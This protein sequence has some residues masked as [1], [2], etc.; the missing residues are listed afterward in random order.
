MRLSLRYSYYYCYYR[1]RADETPLAIKP[2]PSIQVLSSGTCIMYL[3]TS[4]T[5]LEST[6]AFRILI[7]FHFLSTQAGFFFFLFSFLFKKT[8]ANV[9]ETLKERA[10]RKVVKFYMKL[11]I[12]ARR[13]TEAVRIMTN[14]E[15][16]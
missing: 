13:L 5:T 1:P 9:K 15:V 16:V 10:F 12:W 11:Y 7:T 8:N 3:D 14:E 2:N 6:A 4:K